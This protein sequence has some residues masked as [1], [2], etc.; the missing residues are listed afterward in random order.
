MSIL[1][2]LKA[3]ISRS[4]TSAQWIPCRSKLHQCDGAK[5]FFANIG[6]CKAEARNRLARKFP[7]S[8]A[9]LNAIYSLALLLLVDI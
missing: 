9:P 4:E 2:H 7:F 3:F 5:E 1:C 8:G 6:R